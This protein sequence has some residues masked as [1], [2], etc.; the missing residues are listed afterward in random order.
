[1]KRFVDSHVHLW[2]TRINDWYVFPVPENDTFGL[3]LKTPFPKTYLWD[4]YRRDSATVKLEKWVHVSAL[5]V[6]Q[7]VEEES[8]WIAQIANKTGLPHAIIGTL[9]PAL[10]LNEIEATLDREIKNPRYRGA[11]I[12]GG[13]DYES[14]HAT[15]IFAMLAARNLVFD[16]VALP[17]GI[18]T[19]AK[20]L[21]RH[22]KLTVILEHGGWPLNIT[23]QN[24]AEWRSE[25]ADF[26]ALPQ[27]YCKLTGLGMVVHCAEVNIFRK[28]YDTCIDLFSARRCMFGS[29]LPID[30]QYSSGA[31]LLAVFD[32]IAKSRSESEAAD[33]FAGTAERAYR[34]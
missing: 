3:G 14:D 2:D 30:L 27:A 1:V 25:M 16:A 6:P 23:D 28:F 12:L 13:L 34:L 33:L 10:T 18:R 24:F 17:G 29:N 9:N 31:E 20:G 26:A 5:T 32:A 19:A 21:A 7:G 11:R 8:A 4:D 22:P 15:C